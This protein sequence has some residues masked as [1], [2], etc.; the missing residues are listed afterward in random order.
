M[1]FGICTSIENSPAAKAAGWDFIEERVDLLLQGQLA[2]SE[3]KG[4][5]RAKS[6]ALPILA[7]NVLVPAVIKITGPAANLDT[8]D[9]YIK[10]ILS[11]AA[12]IGIKT[13]AFGSAGARN[14]PDGF[15]RNRARAQ[16]VGF[17]K[18]IAPV[19]QRHG[20]T[21][22]VEHLHRNESNIINSVEEAMTYV[23]EVNHPNIRCIIDSFHFWKNDESCDTIAAAAKSI[24]HV[25]VA[26]KEG[27]VAPGLSGSADYRPIF[28]PLKR[29]GY[30]GPICVE[31]TNFDIAATGREVLAFLKN[32]WSSC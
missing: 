16:I 29:S 31:A 14:V 4:L 27:R 26:D 25:H 28:A 7:A 11:R 10:I 9:E 15:D 3:W 17:L 6:S 32:Q 21:V 5:E 30:D 20:L 2:D 22:V 23:R 18:T 19:A 24:V 8:L 12:A 13:L 1:R